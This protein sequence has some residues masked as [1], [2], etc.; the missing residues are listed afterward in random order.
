M[1]KVTLLCGVSNSWGVEGCSVPRGCPDKS[2]EVKGA[3]WSN[4]WDITRKMRKEMGP[5]RRRELG[6]WEVIHTCVV[7]F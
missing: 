2:R 4:C 3:L 5:D 7:S 6:K 1:Q